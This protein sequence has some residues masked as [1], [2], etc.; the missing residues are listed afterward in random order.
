MDRE[1]LEKHFTDILDNEKDVSA[2]VA[3]IRTLMEIIKHGKYTTVQE[4]DENIKTA[5]D[6]MRN[7]DYPVTAINSGCELFL[8]F[9][10]LA[11][12][13]STFEECKQ[14]M[15][16]RGMFFLQKLN[17]ARN[18]ITG[19]AAKFI[20]NGSKVLTH[21]RSRVV[22]Q[23]LKEAARQNKHF[24]VYITMSAPDNNGE[25]FKRELETEGIECS[26]ILDAAVGCIMEKINFVMV[27]AEGVVEN[28]GIINK[29]GTYTVAVCAKQMRK[30]VYVVAESFKFTR[31]FPLNQSDVPDEYKYTKSM[32]NGDITKQ[33]PLVDF[34]PPEFISLLFTDLGI[35]T[36]AAVSD[37]LINLYM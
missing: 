31:L 19:F 11:K 27:G 2:G 36:P 7:T 9:I 14:T 18:K 4:L 25:G 33:H 34:T 15:L 21:S 24:H 3:A 8:R 37:Q 16:D 35:L 20:L 17:Q 30:P 12:L 23:T 29:I 6:V 22:L 5:I 10:T 26:L 13:D 32:R 28:G 1:A